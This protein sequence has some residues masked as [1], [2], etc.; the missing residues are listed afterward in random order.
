[1]KLSPRTLRL[2]K[3]RERIIVPRGSGDARAA[4]RIEKIGQLRL[5]AHSFPGTERVPLAHHGGHVLAGELAEN[6]GIGTGRLDDHH[7]GRHAVIRDGK[8]LRANADQY[9]A[10][11]LDL[12]PCLIRKIDIAADA[13][14]AA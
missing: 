6:L 7:L 8:M 11:L 1:M 14:S 9:L 12:V 5:E 3:K 2:S 4:R 10:A 13:D